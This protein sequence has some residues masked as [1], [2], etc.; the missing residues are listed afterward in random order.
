MARS[1]NLLV[2]LLVLTLHWCTTTAQPRGDLQ[3]ETSTVVVRGQRTPDPLVSRD[4]PTLR[5]QLE[6][7]GAWGATSG[8]AG[9]RLEMQLRGAGGHQSGL[10]LDGVPLHSLRGQAVD[11]SL[12]PFELFESISVERGGDGALGG[13]GTLGGQ[14]SL[15]GPRV[16]N[17][18]RARLLLGG[19]SQRWSRVSAAWG[20]GESERPHGIENTEYRDEREPQ[21]LVLGGSLGGGPN[22]FSYPD[23]RGHH[24]RRARSGFDQASALLRGHLWLGS[25]RL[26]VGAGLSSLRRDEPGPEGFTLP[27]RESDQSLMW[28]VIRDDWSRS[29]SKSEVRLKLLAH[30]L[31]SRYD[32]TEETPLWQAERYS[33]VTFDDAR[34]GLD[35]DLSWS[36]TRLALGSLIQASFTRAL[37]QD[38][39]A[40][41][42][43][44]AL[45]PYLSLTMTPTLILKVT[46]RVDLNSERSAQFVSSTR[47]TW[48]P[49]GVPKRSRARLWISGSQVWRDPGFD[50]RMMRGPGLVPNPDLIPEEGYWGEVGGR[51]TRRGKL[52]AARWRGALSA[53]GFLQMYAYL[54]TYVPLDPYRVRAE[55]VTDAEVLGGEGELNLSMSVDRLHA[56]LDGLMSALQHQTLSAPRAPL[57]LRPQSFGS[58]RVSLSTPISQHRGVSSGELSGWLKVSAR[59][60]ITLDRF[61]ERSLPSRSLWS[62]GLSRSWRLTS[63]Q[64]SLH[65]LKLGLRFDNILNDSTYDF[66]L[67]PLPGRSAWL[68]LMWSRE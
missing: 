44:G 22:N 27:G 16:P 2:G 17:G 25:H 8:G 26:K 30:Y 56:K 65:H 36:S 54:I 24:R 1:L 23:V 31:M 12:V 14:L 53:R 11:L 21:G 9:A 62:A 20:Y 58:L 64:Q 52:G 10:I 5:E 38:S 61:G 43:Q 57:P 48:T 6:A 13:S 60:S 66:A 34:M 49:E 68:S 7:L 32:F 15:S 35:G 33:D 40:K 55:N 51:L 63:A 28:G 42:A 39:E 45:V 18:Q 50:E 59:G 19:S 46:T 41:R 37:T 67:S 4:Q 47:L 3:E 29:F